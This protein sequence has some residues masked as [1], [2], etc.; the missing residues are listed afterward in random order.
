MKILVAAGRIRSI[1]GGAEKSLLSLLQDLSDRHHI[2]IFNIV[3]DDY[4]RIETKW[5]TEDWKWPDL[6]E[7][8][9]HHRALLK[10]DRLA[11]MA[12]EGVFMQFKPDLVIAQYPPVIY[13]NSFDVP[14][15]T[16][17]RDLN[18][19]K[20]YEHSSTVR[21]LYNLP[22]IALKR[23]RMLE[24]LRESNLFITNS[25]FMREQ[26]LLYG[27]DSSV[28]YPFIDCKKAE[29]TSDRI[30]GPV[31]LIAANLGPHKGIDILFRIAERMPSRRFSIAGKLPDGIEIPKNVDYLGWQSDIEQVIA[32][33]SLI[34][35]PSRCEESFGRMPIEAGCQRKPFIAST[36]GGLPEAVGEGGFL[37]EDIENIDLWR[38]KIDDL[39]GNNHIYN[40]MAQRSYENAK[41]FMGSKPFCVFQETVKNKLGIEL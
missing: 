25:N 4:E 33:S 2:K 14:I 6:R 9:P 30:D 24:G 28:I 21:K 5:D 32:A 39:L 7:I 17:V 27:I 16:F 37:I 29:Q 36:R 12:L 41:R 26:F 20:H 11:Q 22:F 3:F 10:K 38:K 13:L 34:L 19:I 35:I 31:S 1:G 18:Y 40:T 15:I 8:K 23:R